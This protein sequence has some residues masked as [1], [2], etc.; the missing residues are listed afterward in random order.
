MLKSQ[1]WFHFSRKRLLRCSIP[2]SDFVVRF[3]SLKVERFSQV[4]WNSQPTRAVMFDDC[5]VPAEN[6]LGTEGSVSL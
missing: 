3:I 6:L 2:S 5:K 4:G 1:F